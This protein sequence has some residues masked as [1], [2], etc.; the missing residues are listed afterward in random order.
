MNEDVSGAPL[1]EPFERA[2]RIFLDSL[3]EDQKRLFL[4]QVSKDE[5]KISERVS[6]ESLFYAADV[7]QKDHERSSNLHACRK[8]LRPFFDVLEDYS[9]ALDV[10]SNIAAISTVLAPLWAGLRVVLQ[11]RM[12][13]QVLKAYSLD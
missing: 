1:I 8:N 6:I 5:R 11:V 10:A 12:L 2:K 13:P 9:K 4:E 3:P 7:S